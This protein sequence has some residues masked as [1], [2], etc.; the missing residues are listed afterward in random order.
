MDAQSEL[1]RE[2]G[3]VIW[4]KN[5]DSEDFTHTFDGV[6]WSIRAGEKMAFPASHAR[7]F[8]KHLSQ[9][10]IMKRKKATAAGK[11]EDFLWK[12]EDMDALKAQILGD[13][14]NLLPDQKSPQDVYKEKIVEINQTLG[15]KV[16]EPESEELTKADII[17]KLK[18]R[19][20]KVDVGRSKADLLEQL[21]NA[22]GAVAPK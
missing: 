10:I 12:K 21:N 14:V 1:A 11:L 20:D 4:F 2:K 9:K 15:E 18:E 13:S 6:P 19:G 17:A 3:L 22:A 7:L 5:I 16:A 8:A